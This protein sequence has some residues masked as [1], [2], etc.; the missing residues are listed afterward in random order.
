MND[1]F[2]DNKKVSKSLAYGDTIFKTSPSV[3]ELLESKGE[4]KNKLRKTIR[5]SKHKWILKISKESNLC[6]PNEHQISAP[7]GTHEEPLISIT[8]AFYRHEA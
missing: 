3:T 4:R 7:P 6:K 2:K 5:W 1:N 8:F